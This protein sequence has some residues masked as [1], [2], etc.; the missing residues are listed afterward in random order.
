MSE[1]LGYI[2]FKEEEFVKKHSEATQNVAFFFFGN[3]FHGF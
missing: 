1:R 3:G 2:A